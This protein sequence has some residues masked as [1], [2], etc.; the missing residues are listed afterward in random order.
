[1]ILKESS[2]LPL[3]RK[4]EILIDELED[5][6]YVPIQSVVTVDEKELCYVKGTDVGTEN[7]PFVTQNRIVMPTSFY[8]N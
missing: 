5:V 7:R 4:V 3:E 2:G 1:M 8:D 6:L